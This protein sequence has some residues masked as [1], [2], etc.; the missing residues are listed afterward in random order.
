MRLGDPY[1]STGRFAMGWAPAMMVTVLLEIVFMALAK[2][3]LMKAPVC[4]VNVYHRTILP[5][6]QG[7]RGMHPESRI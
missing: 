4:P 7:A 1:D 2:L 3:L 6:V 5:K